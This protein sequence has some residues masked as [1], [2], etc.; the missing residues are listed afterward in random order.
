[1]PRDHAPVTSLSY[2][3]NGEARSA[4]PGSTLGDVAAGLGLDPRMLL[5]EHNGEALPK[6]DWTARSLAEGDR[7]EFVRIVAGG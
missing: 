3:L 5:V 2:E 6:G 1:M 4:P 7:V